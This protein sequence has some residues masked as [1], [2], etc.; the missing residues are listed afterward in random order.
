M[1]RLRSRLGVSP[2]PPN[3]LHV[4][5]VTRIVDGGALMSRI[6]TTVLIGLYAVLVPLIL[7]LALR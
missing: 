1:P 7:T 6:E 5:S 4:A 3:M 2:K